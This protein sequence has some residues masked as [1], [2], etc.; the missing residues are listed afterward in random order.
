MNEIINRGTNDQTDGLTD[1]GCK[2]NIRHPNRSGTGSTKRDWLVPTNS[3]IFVGVRH[4]NLKNV[5][6]LSNLFQRPW[7]DKRKTGQWQDCDKTTWLNRIVRI[8][9]VK[10]SALSIMSYT[11]FYFNQTWRVRLHKVFFVTGVTQHGTCDC[12]LGAGW[13]IRQLRFSFSFNIIMDFVCTRAS[14][15]LKCITHPPSYMWVFTIYT[16]LCRLRESKSRS[17]W[18]SK[19]LLTWF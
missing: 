10:S 12:P 2:P 3:I 15:F 16:S 9:K 19:V 7:N 11:D 14:V 4:L 13:N 6:P 18:K 8:Q 5:S 1:W 17:N